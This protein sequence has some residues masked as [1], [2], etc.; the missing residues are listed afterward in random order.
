MDARAPAVRSL[1]TTVYCLLTTVYLS[2]VFASARPEEVDAGLGVVGLPVKP[3]V[4]DGLDARE[5]LARER[6]RGGGAGEVPLAAGLR[7]DE[8]V[9]VRLEEEFERAAFE[10]AVEDADA[11][12]VV[13]EQD[14]E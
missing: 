5:P 4:L 3:V 13:G 6:A 9:G 10:A 2:K 8:G 1:L 11:L 7:V 14:D 12:T